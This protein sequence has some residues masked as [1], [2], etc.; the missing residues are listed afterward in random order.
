M[1]LFDLK[2]LLFSQYRESP[3]L[4]H[5]MITDYREAFKGLEALVSE[6]DRRYQLLADAACRNLSAYNQSGKG[7]LPY[8]VAVLDDLGDFFAVNEWPESLQAIVNLAARGR[9]AG[10]HMIASTQCADPNVLTNS[11]KTHFSTK[12]VF[13]VATFQ[14]SQVIFDKRGAEKLLGQGDMLF[15]QN[16]QTIIRLQG[17]F[18]EYQE[19]DRLLNAIG[20]TYGTAKARRSCSEPSAAERAPMPSGQKITREW[21]ALAEKAVEALVSSEEVSVSMLQRALCIGYN[22]AEYLLDV[23][24]QREIVSKQPDRGSRKILVTSVEDA[25]KKLQG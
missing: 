7:R 11:I 5:P 25:Q 20:E 4:L 8:I 12:I 19:N 15:M 13:Q 22:R 2:M 10:I 18:L 24:E 6:M 21:L 23:L 9:D 3:Y 17:G 1:A 16:D 14:D